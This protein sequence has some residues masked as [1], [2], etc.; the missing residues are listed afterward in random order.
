MQQNQKSNNA[1]FHVF[2]N[3]LKAPKAV[4]RD[5]IVEFLSMNGVGDEKMEMMIEAAE[6]G[7]PFDTPDG[8]VVFKR[9]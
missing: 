6:T 8:R 4:D 3:G 7:V 2:L 9:S 1:T 5:F